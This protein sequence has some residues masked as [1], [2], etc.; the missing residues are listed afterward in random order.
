MDG[1]RDVRCRT[2]SRLLATLAKS[3]VEIH[4]LEPALVIM[5]RALEWSECLG[6]PEL[7]AFLV[8]QR[9]LILFRGGRLAEAESAYGAARDLY[10]E[11]EL[12]RQVADCLVA[13]ADIYAE[14]GRIEAADSAYTQARTNYASTSRPVQQ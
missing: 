8:S 1:C 6:D 10:S 13:L 7:T 14:V 3:T 11:L 12:P 4:G 9:A 2:V 5:N